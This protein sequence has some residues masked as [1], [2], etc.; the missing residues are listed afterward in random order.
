MRILMVGNRMD[1]MKNDVHG[2]CGPKVRHHTA[3]CTVETDDS[4]LIYT[5][6]RDEHDLDR[7]RGQRFDVILEHGSYRGDIRLLNLLRDMVLR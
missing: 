6:L 7:F 3:R 2:M 4:Y 5:V 1:V